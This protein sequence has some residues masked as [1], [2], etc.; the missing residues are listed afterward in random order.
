MNIEAFRDTFIT[1]STFASQQF[2]I[3][4][5]PKALAGLVQIRQSNQIKS[6]FIVWPKITIYT[7][8]HWAL[9]NCADVTSSALRHSNLGEEKLLKKKNPKEDI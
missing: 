4:G 5:P 3:V 8:S 9:T 6:S 7:L 1:L 2:L